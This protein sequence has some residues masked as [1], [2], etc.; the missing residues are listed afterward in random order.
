[1]MFFHIPLQETY[2]A[3]DHDSRTNRLLD[4][5]I[6]GNEPPGSARNNGGLFVNGLLRANESTHVAARRV[7]EVKVVANGHCHITENCRRVQG[8][9]LCFGGGGSYSGYGKI[10]FDRRFRI[11]DISDYGE[12]IST[13]KVTEHDVVFDDMIL[14]GSG[15]PPL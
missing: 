13:Y 11:Y 3:P 1:M 6:H 12:T 8:I 10:G 2:S 15:A 9:W 5:G 7:P 14:A 4:I